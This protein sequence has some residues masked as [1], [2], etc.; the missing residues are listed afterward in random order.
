M[1]YTS[2]ARHITGTDTARTPVGSTHHTLI[3]VPA[4]ILTEAEKRQRL[5]RMKVVATSLLVLMGLVFISTYIWFDHVP[6]IGYV[7]AMTEAAMVGALADWFAVTALFRHP[8][9]LPIPHTAIIA[10]RKDEIGDNLA[11]FVGE[12]FLNEQALRPR[13]EQMDFGDA[14]GRWLAQPRNATRV[15]RDVAALLVWL[16]QSLDDHTVREFLRENLNLSLREL[17]LAPLLGRILDLLASSDRHHELFD[18]AINIASSQLSRNKYKIRARIEDRSPWWMPGFVDKEIYDKIVI[19]LEQAIE[20]MGTDASHPARERFTQS[21]REFIERLK[22]DEQMHLRAEQIKQELLDDPSL[23]NYL[24]NLWSK[25]RDYL[26]EQSAIEDSA[27]ST[28][29]RDALMRAGDALSTN[30]SMR[31][32]V[33]NW[34]RHGIVRS[35]SNYRD[36]MASVISDTVRAWDGPATANRV[37]LQVGRDLQFIRINGTIVGGLAGL[38]IY[39]LLQVFGAA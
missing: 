5:R 9:G 21:V 8:L 23:Q 6:W 36:E 28:R 39:A 11:S 2:S 22:T 10:R 12:N 38:A 13:V 33:N 34:V 16:L 32:V 25:L 1:R 20:S 26:A 27:L 35:V 29:L 37:E 4:P 17:Q 15:G 18:R 19:E 7:R 3:N 14:I 31:T 24:T 30:S